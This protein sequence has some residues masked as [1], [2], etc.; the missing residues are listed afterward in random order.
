MKRVVFY[1]LT[2]LC[3]ALMLSGCAATPPRQQDN[4]CQIFDQHGDWYDYAHRSEKRWGTPIAVQM[5]FVQQESSFRARA[6]P[7]RRKILGF[8]P[9]PRPSS[10]KGYAQAQDPAWE[11]YQKAT[12]RRFAR[13]TDMEDALDFIGWYNDVSQRRLGLSKT[14][15][16][17]LYLAYH[18]GHSGFQ[19]G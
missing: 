7:E 4:L 13:R 5:A 12:G 15:A 9:G 11:D 6:R 17:H 10:A 16:F 14:D 19:R 1:S 18:D 2:V 3:F 8:I